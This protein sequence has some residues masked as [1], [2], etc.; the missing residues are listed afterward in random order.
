MKEVPE[1]VYVLKRIEHSTGK[2]YFGVHGLTPDENAFPPWTAVEY[3]P[4]ADSLEELVKNL[5]ANEKLKKVRNI[6]TTKRDFFPDIYKT[7]EGKSVISFY[8][9][10]EQETRKFTEYFQRALNGEPIKKRHNPEI[11]DEDR[12]KAEGEE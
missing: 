3:M 11:T 1:L 10:D 9:L 5:A 6:S 8:D 2:K 12:A 4:C 7:P